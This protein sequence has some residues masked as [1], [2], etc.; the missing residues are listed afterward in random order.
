[1][2]NPKET[3]KP[4]RSVFFEDTENEEQLQEQGGAEAES[5]AVDL[6]AVHGDRVRLLNAL[7]AVKQG[8]F[9]VRLPV[10]KGGIMAEIAILFNDVV[11]INES[12]ANEIIRVSKIVGEEGK[13]TERASLGQ[14]A[15]SWKASVDS[16]N[17]LVN[18][19]AQPTTEVGRVITAVAEGDLTK[20]MRLEI[21]E[22]PLK[23][24]FLRIGTRV[25]T[26]VDQLSSFAEEVTRVAKEV[27]TEGKLGGQAEVK[28]V[29]GVWKGLT[30]NVNLMAANLT[31]QVRNIAQVT[32]AVAMGDLSQKIT[33]EAKGEILQL[34]DTINKMV[35]QLNAFASEVTRVAK[36]VGTEGKLGGQAEVK[37]V[38]GTWKDLTDNVNK[39]AA[40]LTDQVRNIAEVTTAV[41]QGEL[42]KKIT[43]E[44]KGEIF[45]LKSTVNTMVDQLGAFAAEVTRVAKEVGTDGKLGGQAEVKGVSGVWKGL[46][47]N[48]NFMA[49]NLTAQVRNIAQVTT[50]VANGDLSLKI[51]AEAK[52]EILQLKDTINKM[53]DQLN[54]FGSEVTRVAREVG[55]D[56]KLGGQAVVKGVAGVWKDLT[57]NVNLMAAN[58]T[59]QVRNIAQVTTAVAMGDLSQ[60][61]TAEAKGEILQL[62]DTINKMVD[63]LNGFA[64]EVTRVAKEVGTD[65]KLGGQAEVKGVSGTWKDLTENVNRMAANLTSQVRNI[66]LVTTSVAEGDLSKKITVEAKGE[67]MELKNTINTMVDQLN[68]FAAEV[69]R[70]AKEVGTDGKLG[71]QAAVPGVAGTWKNLTDNVNAMAGSLTSQVRNIAEVT[72][73]VA[74]GNLSK[75]ITVEAKGE[76]QE[77]KNTINIMVDQLNAFAAEVTR[78]AKEVGTDGK[79]G[80]QASVKGVAGV[81]KDLTDNVNFMAANLTSQVR[82]IALV[83]TSVAEGDLSK[84]ITVEAKGEIQELKNTINIMVDQLN[85]FAAEVTRVAREVGTDGKL[86]GQASVKGGAGVWKDLTDN[87]NLMASNLTGQVR[88]I[89]QV[90]TAV[91]NGD[92]SQKITAEAKGEILQL[93][94]TINRMVDQLNSFA[95]EVTR[96]A[97]EVGTDGKLGGQAEVKGVSGTW[98]DLTEN[99]N[100]MAANLTSQVRNIAQV[101]IAV[102]MGDLSQKITAEAKGEILQLKDTMNKMVDQL[103]SFAA[104]VTRVAKEVGTDGKLGGQAEVPG[105]AGTW[106]N[107]TDNVNAMAS[108]LTSQVRNIA[109]VTTAVAQGNLAK[110]IT[111]EARGE[112]LQLKDTINKMVDQLNSFAA[113][114][115]RVAREVGT[116]GKLGGQAVVKG[117]SGTWKDLT[118]NVNLMAANLTGQVRNIALVTTA[119]ANG[120]LS[121]KITV[122]AK[123]EILQLKDT[124]NRMVDQ[125]NAFAAEVTR[126]AREVGMEGKLGGQAI[127]RG[128]AGI[129]K[130]LTD[131]V[132]AMASSLTSQ[133]RDI[134]MVASA[135]ADGDL[136]QKITVEAKGEIQELKSTINGMVDKLG[137]IIGEINDVMALVGEGTLTRLIEAAASGEFASMV[138][139]INGTIESLRGIVTELR[140]AGVNIGSVSQNMLGAGEEM[141]QMVSQTSTSVEQIAEGAKTQAQ[142]ISG[143]L[144]ESEG[145]GKTASN[146]LTQAESM[147]KA[148]EIANKA[149]GEGGKAM[150]STIQNTELMLEGSKE[151]VKRI[152]A[153]SKSS[154]QIQEIVDVIRDIATQTN[155]LAINAA[156]E[157]VRAGKQGKGFAVV[158]EEV[159][160]LSADSKSQAKKISTLVQAVMK[161]TEETVTTI[162]TMA[163]N[164]ELGKRS[165]EQTSKAFGDINRSIETTSGTAKEISVAAADQKKSIDAISESLDKISGIAADTSSS[166]TQSAEGSKRLLSKT[167]E[168]MSTATRLASMSEKLQQTVGRFSVEETVSARRAVAAEP[169]KKLGEEPARTKMKAGKTSGVS[170]STKG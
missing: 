143:A 51:T 14:V 61:I 83:T 157:A 100:R 91:A 24:E 38:S 169:K 19:L 54:G 44:A 35:D 129:W 70:V 90:T 63:Q 9:S 76:I 11:G 72:T 162:K 110:K 20:K 75:K 62:K 145:V 40:N 134:A 170:K 122:E 148:T 154:E 34:K 121:Q 159:K 126:V 140:D 8:D 18:N 22:R 85:A 147:N 97:K 119:V 124:I 96:V 66:A 52:G 87:V 149:A 68:A 132:N 74:E 115:T 56:G 7:K 108:G 78:V 57:D 55:T 135:L 1:M 41:A 73:A 26:M 67:I 112:I 111:V 5:G 118:D 123:G 120:D 101:T 64:S 152:E 28:G 47:D 144:K 95:A 158:A 94:D 139:G 130:D 53:V 4:G 6:K 42:T 93:K 117:V 102:A 2:P 12:L 160:T 116:D 37:G 151:S 39:M 30:D 113:E 153:L 81:W 167:Q 156:I 146:T 161:E 15:G 77:L 128:V 43:V 86:G 49:A 127:V 88:N 104:E 136:S 138:E 155:I 133:V 31:A 142:Q 79:L 59:G 58:L 17:A 36:E 13:L 21:E 80:G 125:L 27:G 109:E 150:E 10:D 89:A 137:T 60:K 29:S 168:L 69:T 48:V 33:A 99:V 3:R 65:G 50:S 16:I 163:Q 25:N 164:V 71:G 141:N 166:S 32:T 23:G 98:K 114:V 107:L 106:K 105:V 92:L 165:I 84:K 82:N 45:K 46:T 131:N 103:N